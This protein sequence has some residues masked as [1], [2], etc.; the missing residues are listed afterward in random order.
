MD[1]IEHCI[2]QQIELNTSKNLLYAHIEQMIEIDPGF[3]AALEELLISASRNETKR[4]PDDIVSLT[5][6]ALL[7]KL[8]SI[9]Q[10]VRISR[11]N[12]KELEQIYRRTWQIMLRTGNVQATLR[13]H[14]Y[15]ELSRWLM[16]LYPKNVVKYLRYSPRI[17]RVVCEEYSAD[18]QIELFH[19]KVSQIQQPVLD[20]GCGSRA[21]LVRY[22]RVLGID[23]YG[24]D[25]FLDTQGDYLEQADW[26]EYVFEPDRWGTII[27]NMAF[28]NHLIYTYHHDRTQLERYLL[29]MNN[30]IQSL[31]IGGSFHY[32]PSLPFV[33]QRLA[34]TQY[35]VVRKRI[36]DEIGVSTIT[37]ITG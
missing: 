14:H 32:A 16:P 18:F 12:V 28:T 6:Q 35:K 8:Y 13:T 3:V 2:E 34:P 26:F 31:G 10:Y 9:N 21:N 22:L 17:G 25:R 7:K 29:T 36:M 37:R 15:P 24:I 19:L 27:S 20:I 23:A 30:I 5:V 33:E 11:D 4:V 1:T